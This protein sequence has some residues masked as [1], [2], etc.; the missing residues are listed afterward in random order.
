MTW[1]RDYAVPPK[2]TGVSN[3]LN[4]LCLYFDEKGTCF[5]GQKKLAIRCGLTE[6]TIAKHLKALE[7]QNYISRKP[8][9]REGGSRTSDFYEL[10]AYHEFVKLY[11][12]SSGLPEDSSVMAD[13]LQE[14]T[15]GKPAE[16]DTLPEDFADLTGR[17]FRAELTENVQIKNNNTPLPPTAETNLETDDVVVTAETQNQN[18]TSVASQTHSTS[19]AKTEAV[20]T[21]PA[22]DSEGSVKSSAA[23][24]PSAPSGTPERKPTP[25]EMLAFATG[26]KPYRNP[27]IQKQTLEQNAPQTY[28]ALIDLKRHT[29]SKPGKSFTEVVFGRWVERLLADNQYH[30]DEVTAHWVNACIDGDANNP[31]SYYE[32][33]KRK[34]AGQTFGPSAT[35]APTLV[36]QRR[37]FDYGDRVRVQGEG[38]FVVEEILYSGNIRVEDETTGEWREF[39]MDRVEP[40]QTGAT[41]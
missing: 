17:Y 11:I 9:Y 4:S 1:V 10:V 12:A 22:N 5:P 26:G 24:L 38:V 27:A 25:A 15:S 19:Q 32:A 35:A 31:V 7:E 33:L 39:P 2:G 18:P 28:A 16:N 21:A 36:R 20:D 40:L 30:G 8:R 23:A 37:K 13:T 14:N 29:D 6:R 34:G 41:A 3:T